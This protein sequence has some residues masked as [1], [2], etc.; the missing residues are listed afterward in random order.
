MGRGWAQHSSMSKF[1]SAIFRFAYSF[2]FWLGLIFCSDLG[3][4]A[5]NVGLFPRVGPLMVAYGQ[6]GRTTEMVDYD[7]K[8]P[9]M[10]GGLMKGNKNQRPQ[11]WFG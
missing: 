9:H 10:S 3:P 7:S 11:T 6:L 4:W 5:S 1:L 2:E 8:L